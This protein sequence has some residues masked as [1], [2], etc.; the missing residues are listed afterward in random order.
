[1]H[2]TPHVRLSRSNTFRSDTS[3]YFARKSEV[4]FAHFNADALKIGKQ[5]GGVKMRLGFRFKRSAVRIL[6]AGIIA[7]SLSINASA[8]APYDDTAAPAPAASRAPTLFDTEPN[9]GTQPFVPTITPLQMVPI[10]P[11]AASGPP[12]APPFGGPLFTRTKLTGDWGGVRNDLRDSGY[13]IDFSN[14][15]YY[16]GVASGGTQQS[17]Q[18]GGRNDLYLNVDGEKA[19]LWKGLFVTVHEE[20]RYGNGINLQ[21]GALMPANLMMLLPQPGGTV[22][23]LTAVKVTQFLSENFLVFGGRLNL[24]D[25]LQ[26]QLTGATQNT[27]F[28]NTS[29]MF[30]PILARTAP[31]STY[32]AGFAV[33]QN[34][35]PVLSVAILDTNNVPTTIGIKDSLFAN[36]MTA[37]GQ[38]N[39]PTKFLNLPG[40]QGLIGTYSNGSY[41]CLQPTPYFD[42]ITGLGLKTTTQSSSWSFGYS[43]D[44]ALW[45]SSTN[46][47]KVW[48]VFGNIG[49]SDGN[50]NP[51]RSFYNVGISG[52]SPFQRR[53]QD[54][55]GVGY[56]YLDVTNALKDLAPNLLPLKNEEGVELYYNYAVTPWFHVTPDFQVLDPFRARIDNAVVAGV[57]AKIDF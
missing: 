7:T 5:Q 22:E 4:D 52:T 28:M 32:G 54:T 11:A 34:L 12:P 20:S 42:P 21:T 48:G 37:L 6:L 25:G 2:A 18:Y 36:G 50:P 39:I 10:A 35:E 19:G 38:L 44:Q 55:F 13:T 41:T 3:A 17:F 16:Q 56:Y 23:G 15:Q 29:F 9:A 40:H 33:L 43:F 51:V 30:N 46:P 45:V 1:M 47:K 26:Q 49:V 31:Y 53:T 24:L 14:T 8:Q 27:G 57:R